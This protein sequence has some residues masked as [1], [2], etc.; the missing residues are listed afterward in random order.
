M[1]FN[2][3]H[4]TITVTFLRTLSLQGGAGKLVVGALAKVC[5][6]WKK[7]QSESTLEA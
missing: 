4:C 7:D 2:G 3:R 1:I 5:E 6:E